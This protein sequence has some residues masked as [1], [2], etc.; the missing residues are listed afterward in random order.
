MP[1]ND[2]WQTIHQRGQQ[3][4]AVWNTHA[5]A[6]TVGTLTLALHQADVAALPAA[7]QAL[8]S[9]QDVVDAARAA[10]DAT[11][12]L[13]KDL[14]TR[15]PRVL[16]GALDFG[17]PLH[18][19]LDDIRL[20]EITGLD[21]IISRGQRVRSVW[22]KVNVRNAALVPPIPALVVGSKTVADLVAALTELPVKTQAVEDTRSVLSDKRSSLRALAGKVDK[23]NKRWYAAW[24]GNFPAGSP[25]RDALTQIDTGTPTP[26]PTVLLIAS[27]SGINATTVQV[28]YT[29]GG[30]AHASELELQWQLAGQP[31]WTVAGD[32]TEPS[33]Q[34]SEPDFEQATVRFRTRAKNSRGEVFSPVVEIG[35]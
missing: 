1:S 29:A 5:P 25:E 32:A 18:G 9:E 33:Q 4:N 35:L 13:I 7:G 12:D 14:A 26:P 19:D 22:E 6:F 8:A 27:L 3:T 24:E 11:C 16:D 28:S 34:V 30:G 31:D 23:N 10:R 20:V 15:A 17:D 2:T 21:T